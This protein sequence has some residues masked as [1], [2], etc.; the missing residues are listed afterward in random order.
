[1]NRTLLILAGALF[2]GGLFVVYLYREEFIANETGGVPVPVLVA[3]IDIPIGVPVRD[4][5]LTVRYIPEAYVEGRHIPAE[6]RRE[7]VG[8]PLAQAV[9]ENETLLRTDLSPLSD[10]RHTLSSNVPPGMRAITLPTTRT[11]T[12]V[13]LLQPGDRVDVIL[14]IGEFGNPQAGRGV[15]VLQ[16][17]LVLAYGLEVHRERSSSGETS[18]SVSTSTNVT[19]QLTVDE[20]ALLTQARSPQGYI[21]LV[22]RNPN[23][24]VVTT[25]RVPDVR[26]EDMVDLTRRARFLRVAVRSLI[27]PALAPVEP[28]LD[29][30]AAERALGAGALTPGFATRPG[31]TTSP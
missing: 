15:V 22:L 2:F 28:A 27:P 1:M 5:W 21:Q 24:T 25:E 11:S 30:A 20:S 7:I 23:D 13:G 19:L 9:H 31:P 3:F 17:V 16:N 29:P 12:H 26:W 6:M 18:S 10:A 8:L 4:E 14:S